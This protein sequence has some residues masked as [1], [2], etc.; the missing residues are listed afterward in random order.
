MFEWVL[1]ILGSPVV[2]EALQNAIAL[3]VAALVGVAIS[4]LHKYAKRMGWEAEDTEAKYHRQKIRDVV[5]GVEQVNNARKKRGQDPLDPEQKLSLAMQK[6]SGLGFD[7]DSSE[8]ESAV[9]W[10]N[11]VSARGP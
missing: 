8:V 10:L 11:R 5:V 2:T 6:L 9:W 7:V 1:E 4:A 3:L